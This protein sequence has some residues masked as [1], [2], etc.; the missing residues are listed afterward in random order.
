MIVVARPG[1]EF[2]C[3]AVRKTNIARLAI[4]NVTLDWKGLFPS[5]PLQKERLLASLAIGREAAREAYPPV[6]G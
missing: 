5:G 3:D 6:E 4:C 1:G 2:D